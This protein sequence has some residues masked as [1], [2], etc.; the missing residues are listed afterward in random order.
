MAFRDDKWKPSTAGGLCS[1]SRTARWLRVSSQG[2]RCPGPHWQVLDPP[3]SHSDGHRPRDQ[4]EGRVAVSNS[5]DALEA[6]HERPGPRSTVR[7]PFS[8]PALTQAERS[9]ACRQGRLGQCSIGLTADD[10][11]PLRLRASA[12]SRCAVDAKL[13]RRSVMG[14]RSPGLGMTHAARR[15]TQGPREVATRTGPALRRRRA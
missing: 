4:T 14:A 12:P 11:C 1:N 5:K 13:A 2:W 15:E 6:N 8:P 7:C 3:A 9:T 10:H